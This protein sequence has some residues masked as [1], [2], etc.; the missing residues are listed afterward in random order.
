[1]FFLLKTTGFATRFQWSKRYI[2]LSSC[3]WD[4]LQN[5]LR[6]NGLVCLRYFMYVLLDIWAQRT[7]IKPIIDKIDVVGVCKPILV[8]GFAFSQAEQQLMSIQLVY[9]TMYNDLCWQEQTI[10]SWLNRFS[11][12][13]LP[14]LDGWLIYKCHTTCHTCKLFYCQPKPRIN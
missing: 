2:D 3:G 13:F 14:Y 10:Q 4:I 11:Q 7:Q 12:H 9:C 1:M 5:V 6:F 8:F